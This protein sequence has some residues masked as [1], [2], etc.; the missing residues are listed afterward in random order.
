MTVKRD[1]EWKSLITGYQTKQ[2]KSDT[3]NYCSLALTIKKGLAMK[4]SKHDML[5]VYKN[6]LLKLIT[7]V[8][9]SGQHTELYLIIQLYFKWVNYFTLFQNT[10]WD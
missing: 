2:E 9:V 3:V 7:T 10:Q 5:A 4:G 6:W 1:S 8:N